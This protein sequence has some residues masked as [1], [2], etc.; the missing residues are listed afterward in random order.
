MIG[1]GPNNYFGSINGNFKISTLEFCN[2]TF[3]DNQ[4]KSLYGGGIGLIIE[5]IN[6]I[7]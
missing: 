3:N 6:K 5:G 1:T 4:C 7:E 2:I